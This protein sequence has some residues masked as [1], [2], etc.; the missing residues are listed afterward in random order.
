MNMLTKIMSFFFSFFAKTFFYLFFIFYFYF[1][2]NMIWFEI[3]TF[4]YMMITIYYHT[5]T[6]KHDVCYDLQNVLENIYRL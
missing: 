6:P 3:M 4:V 1:F 2:I 5:K